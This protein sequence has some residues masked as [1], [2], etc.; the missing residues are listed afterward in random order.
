M[1]MLLACAGAAAPIMATASAVKKKFFNLKITIPSVA[2]TFRLPHCRYRCHL[3][4]EQPDR[5]SG[6]GE[7][8]RDVF[9]F[10][11]VTAALRPTR[12]K[13]GAVGQLKVC[14]EV[15]F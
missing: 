10:Q 13:K 2:R 15:D 5:H 6:R 4:R 8:I 3:S 11:W 9:P 1:V 7:G 14:V 12:Q